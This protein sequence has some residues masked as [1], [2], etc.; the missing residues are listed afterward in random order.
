MTAVCQTK[1]ELT[2]VSESHS[3]E[4]RSQSEIL[5]IMKNYSFKGIPSQDHQFFKTGIIWILLSFFFFNLDP[6]GLNQM[7][8]LILNSC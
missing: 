8:L 4:G 1:V 3:Q 6:I 7:K 2:L 5:G